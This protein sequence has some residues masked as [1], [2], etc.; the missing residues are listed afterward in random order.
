MPKDSFKGRISEFGK[1]ADVQIA[2]SNAM[3]KAHR[4]RNRADAQGIYCRSSSSS[5]SY[6][7]ASR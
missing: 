3:T 1:K 2:I 6:A 5:G 7:A 4:E